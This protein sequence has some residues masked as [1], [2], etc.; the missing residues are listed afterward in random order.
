MTPCVQGACHIIKT[1]SILV[2]SFPSSHSERSNTKR[3]E[4]RVG[5]G[6]SEARAKI[7][8]SCW[9]IYFHQGWPECFGVGE[10]DVGTESLP[11]CCS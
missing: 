8:L 7:W 1:Q 2:P 6:R 4:G 3:E 5:R 11:G 10:V 9:E